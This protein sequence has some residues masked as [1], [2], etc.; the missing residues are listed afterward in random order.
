[1]CCVLQLW[2]VTF[3]AS[4]AVLLKVTQLN[5]WSS[6]EHAM[7]ISGGQA[8]RDVCHVDVYGMLLLPEVVLK[9]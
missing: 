1:M 3:D 6:Y 9:L 5:C 7:I 2:R 8:Q 4:V